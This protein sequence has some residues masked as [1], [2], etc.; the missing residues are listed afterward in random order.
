LKPSYK[1]D[2]KNLIYL[3]FT[4]FLLQILKD[5]QVSYPG[6]ENKLYQNLIIYKNN[7]FELLRAKVNKTREETINNILNEYIKLY[8]E[9]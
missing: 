2:K 5:F 8:L 9:G 7:I 4:L 1:I 3:I 6:K